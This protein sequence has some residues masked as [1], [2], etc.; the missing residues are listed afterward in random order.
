LLRET[1]DDYL[2]LIRSEKSREII[3]RHVPAESLD[4]IT[5]VMGGMRR[6]GF[7]LAPRDA[8]LLR[9]P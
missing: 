1:R 7:G 8:D 6:P 2:V 4:R 3:E 5:Y 9:R